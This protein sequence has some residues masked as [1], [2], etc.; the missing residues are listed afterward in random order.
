MPTRGTDARE[1]IAD[2]REY[3]ADALDLLTARRQGAR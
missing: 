3:I 2:A 1:Y